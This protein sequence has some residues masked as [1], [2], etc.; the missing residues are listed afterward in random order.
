MSAFAQFVVRWLCHD[1]A[2]PIASVM[3]A[4]ELL[5]NDVPDAEINDLIQS[6]ARRLT[7]RLRLVRLALGAGE[8]AMSG[9]A[10]GKLVMAGLDGTP[11]DWGFHEDA[12][13]GMAPLVAGCAMLVADLNRMKGIRVS[14][15]GVEVP[16]GCNWPESVAAVF[17]GA[18]ATDNR[19]A[20]AEMLVASA[21]R[22]GRRLSCDASGLQWSAADA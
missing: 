20:V 1:L 3:T 17:A 5:D 14:E 9:T 21:T 2:T 18:P 13:D 16:Q 10:L 11:V 4:S 7:G 6:G 22:A 15:T 19:S 8:N 12:T